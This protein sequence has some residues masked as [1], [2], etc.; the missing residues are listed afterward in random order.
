VG[1]APGV[2]ADASFRTIDELAERCGSYCWLE[3]RLFEL[4][5]RW[6]SAPA[7]RPGRS[8]PEIRLF[9][10]EMS[11]RHGFLAGQWHDRLP[12]RA[13]VD[14]NALVVPPPGPAREALD[15]FGADL[16][17]VAV[18]GGLVEHILPRLLTTY[19]DHLV[20][21]SPVGEAPVRA[22]LES[23]GFRGGPEVLD[24]RALLQRGVQVVEDAQ[25]VS[26]FGSRL[27]GLLGADLCIIPA[28]R[29]S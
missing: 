24:G 7:I 15:L 25:R 1:E 2:I 4:T 9:L 26:D 28:A 20:R 13:G 29:A 12:V 16:D 21:A 17:L 23:A 19:G 5:G 11:A 6:A 3:I 14:V 10:S 22:V 18:L 8:D 27:D